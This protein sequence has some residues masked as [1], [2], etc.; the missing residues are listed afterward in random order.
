MDAGTGGAISSIDCTTRQ[1]SEFRSIVEN[2]LR[3]FLLHRCV[4]QMSCFTSVN[5]LSKKNCLSNPPPICSIPGKVLNDDEADCDLQGLDPA[6]TL[7]A[8]SAM[9]PDPTPAADPEPKLN[10]A[11]SIPGLP[12]HTRDPVA[13]DPSGDKQLAPPPSLQNEGNVVDPSKIDGGGPSPTTQEVDPGQEAAFKVKGP[14][15]PIPYPVRSSPAEAAQAAAVINLSVISPL[16]AVQFARPGS[17]VDP[18]SDQQNHADPN[19]LSPSQVAQL[20]Q[21]LVPVSIHSPETNPGNADPHEKSGSD[22]IEDQLPTAPSPGPSAPAHIV[23][24]TGTFEAP[25]TGTTTIGS[26]T[27][28]PNGQGYVVNGQQVNSNAL[29]QNIDNVPVQIQGP[30]EDKS[31][32]TGSTQSPNKSEAPENGQASISS[33][34]TGKDIPSDS[35]GS[36]LPQGSA[37]SVTTIAGLPV[38][39]NQGTYHVDGKPLLPGS[40]IA[41]SGTTWSVGSQSL[42][43]IHVGDQVYN[44][45]KTEPPPSQSLR[46]PPGPILIVPGGQVLTQAPNVPNA[47]IVSGSTVTVQSGTVMVG[48]SAI[49]VAT[50]GASGSNNG[51]LS[52][53]NYV[54]TPMQGGSEVA[55]GGSILSL[56]G[57]GITT[58]GTKISLASA[59]LAIGSSTYAFATPAQNA[60]ATT[61]ARQPLATGLA[62]MI[63][64]AFVVAMVGAAGTASSPSATISTSSSSTPAATASSA[65]GSN[66]QPPSSSAPGPKSSS[67]SSSNASA[68]PRPC[69]CWSFL[70]GALLLIQQL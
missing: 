64:N 2:L 56:N 59:G 66:T 10:P 55:Y 33:P 42:P 51:A 26:H 39:N 24:G 28:A 53:G 11:Q 13:N 47:Y 43:V 46:V 38:V 22:H 57:P 44:L 27:V 17:G 41:I 69:S 9:I 68:V 21:A 36:Q 14:V 6:R 61:T 30:A 16:S 45:P 32:D 63:M 18:G 67:E 70:L 52:V 3:G 5:C 54:F 25:S 4:F 12:H 49:A 31:P 60:A 29:P 37:L 62:G 20:H 34:H 65:A 48:S 1:S 40:E 19:E 7:A 58:N 35:V 23:I 50:S 15:Q 8:T